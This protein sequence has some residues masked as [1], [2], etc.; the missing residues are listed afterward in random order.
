[1]ATA[2]DSWVE[3]S[4][5]IT[6]VVM[7]E[8][9]KFQPE[10]FSGFGITEADAEILDLHPEVYERTQEQTLEL[11]GTLEERKLTTENPRVTQDIDILIK[12][13]KDQYRTAELNQ[14]YLLPYF[15]LPQTLYFGFQGLLD[16]RNDPARFPAALERLK[17]YTGQVSGTE[18]ITSLAETRTAE[19]FSQAGLLGPYRP[20]L[21]KDLENV[22]RFRAG[23]EQV[24]TESG[25]EGW[26]D[27][28]AL[29]NTQLD[30]YAA[31]LTRELLPRTRPSHL[32]PEELYADNLR[33]FG[34]DMDPRQLIS[35]AQRGFAEIQFQMQSIAQ[36]IAKQNGYA[37]PDYRAVLA[38]LTREQMPEDTV[39]AI[40]RDRLK[41][42][43]TIIRD[44]ALVTLPDRDAV[45]RANSCWLRPIP[46]MKAVSR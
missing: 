22:A 11:I 5:A 40:Y 21:E 13:L 27:D 14:N 20:Q 8:Q 25:L 45:S 32:L 29:L 9:A 46:R 41:D 34:V 36:Q 3:E 10:G 35:A 44:N 6:A 18:A 38:E 1:L 16:P 19:R 30:E 33:N 26:Q 15:N 12:A 4:N 39:L 31:W 37:D 23:L 24:F 2:A 43:E 17:K 42:L 28:L 7:R